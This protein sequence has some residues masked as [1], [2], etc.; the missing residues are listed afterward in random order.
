MS[1]WFCR[2]GFSWRDLK[3]HQ[4]HHS[5][6]PEPNHLHNYRDIRTSW[7]FTS[8]SLAGSP[9]T[10]KQKTFKRFPVA[11]SGRPSL[12]CNVQGSV[13]EHGMGREA[14]RTCKSGLLE[15]REVWSPGGCLHWLYVSF[16]GVNLGRCLQQRLTGKMV[17]GVNNIFFFLFKLF[18]RYF[19][20]RSFK[21]YQ[22]SSNPV[23]LFVF[24]VWQKSKGL[25]QTLRAQRGNCQWHS[26]VGH[27]TIFT[28]CLTNITSCPFKSGKILVL[29]PWNPVPSH[30]LRSRVYQDL[31]RGIGQK[32]FNFL[33]V[34]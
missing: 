25:Y 9:E 14:R 15:Q 13:W 8:L 16:T 21:P 32:F 22:I 2:P 27:G 3:S 17:P 11:W 26:C 4:S 18:S 33:F 34:R 7:G 12:V 5:L 20:S 24:F 1:S 19:P 10:N 23:C 31:G 6:S 29:C 30:H 28:I